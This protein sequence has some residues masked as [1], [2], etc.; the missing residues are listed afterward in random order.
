MMFTQFMFPNGRRQEISRPMPADIESMADEL[1]A[2][3]WQFEIECNPETQKVHM[4]CSDDESPLESRI[5]DN[6][7]TVPDTVADLVRK[8]HE[9]WVKIGRPRAN[10]R[11]AESAYD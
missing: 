5:V 10:H 9:R 4:D 1:V 2:A 3:G 6:G 11:V 7:P 8:S